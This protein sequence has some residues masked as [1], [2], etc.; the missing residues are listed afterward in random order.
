MGHDPI[1]NL[2]SG[3]ILNSVRQEKL[4]QEREGI[5]GLESLRL[6]NGYN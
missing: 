2:L 4:W 3:I 5:S 6:P 1:D